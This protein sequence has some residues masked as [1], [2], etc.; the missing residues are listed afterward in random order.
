MPGTGAQR[1][2]K[3]PKYIPKAIKS[4]PTTANQINA[5]SITQVGPQEHRIWHHEEPPE[6]IFSHPQITLVH[7]TTH[8]GPH[9]DCHPVPHQGRIYSR[10][11]KNQLPDT[12]NRRGTYG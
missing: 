12:T 9:L 3:L 10:D 2:P 11:L 5:P 4:I 8:H 1:P 7:Y 6:D